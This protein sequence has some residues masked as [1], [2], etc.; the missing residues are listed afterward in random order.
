MKLDLPEPF[1]PMSTVACGIPDISTSARE[2]KPRILM[3]SIPFVLTEYRP[4]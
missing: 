3:D 4:N 2:R 1:A